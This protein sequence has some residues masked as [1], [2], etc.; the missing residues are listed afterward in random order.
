M[1][2]TA[3]LIGEA[4]DADVAAISA[5]LWEAWRQAG[6]GAPGF[7][8][9]T[10]EVI[11]D[12]ADPGLI[13][14][15]LGGPRHRMYVARAGDRVVG[16]ASTRADTDDTIELSGIVVLQNTIGT[17]IGTKLLDAAMGASIGYGFTTMTVSTETSNERAIHFYESH[18]FA[19]TGAE[20]EMVEETPVEVVT[21][22]RDL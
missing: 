18:G 10:E 11:A 13:R 14:T 16:F 8:G 15:R 22:A 7:S 5:F 21:L 20:L 2:E 4:T 9:A 6:P 3:P 1:P 19:V 17:G 12:V